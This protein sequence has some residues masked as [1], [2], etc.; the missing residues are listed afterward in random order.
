MSMRI[1]GGVRV[2]FDDDPVDE[3]LNVLETLTSGSD[4]Q[5][6]VVCRDI[7]CRSFR[8]YFDSCDE[9]QVAEHRIECFMCFV[10]GFHGCTS[11]TSRNA[12]P[13]S[14]VFLFAL[15][16]SVALFSGHLCSAPGSGGK[17]TGF[18]RLLGGLGL[19][20]HPFHESLFA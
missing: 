4:E 11:K 13:V 9:A 7:Q 17:T 8:V 20:L 12:A 16:V 1:R 10:E 15:L 3:V 18:F 5:L 2:A 14:A 6:T 19:V